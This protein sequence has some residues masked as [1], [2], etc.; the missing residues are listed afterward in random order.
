MERNR[1]SVIEALR[2][3][4]TN[5]SIVTTRD[6]ELLH[7]MT[8]TAWAEAVHPPRVLV[9]MNREAKTYQHVQRS[10]IFAVNLLSEAQEDLAVRFGRSDVP[11]GELFSSIGYRTEATGS[12]VLDGCVAFFDCRVEGF[13]PFGSFD[14]VTGQVETAGLGAADKPLVYYASR[15]CRLEPFGQVVRYPP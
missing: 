12:P 11:H 14:I 15:L 7:G 2:H 13:Y 8:A 4:A 1:Q 5:V 3:I 6:G 10:G 9:T